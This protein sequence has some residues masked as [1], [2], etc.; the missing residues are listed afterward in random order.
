LDLGR[1]RDLIVCS[2]KQIAGFGRTRRRIDQVSC[3]FLS[4]GHEAIEL[5]VPCLA[6]FALTPAKHQ[7]E[8]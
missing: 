5:Q 6:A 3:S 2:A 7:Y 4:F 1:Q 8:A